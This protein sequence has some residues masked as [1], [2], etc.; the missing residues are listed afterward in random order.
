MRWNESGP[1][2]E[3]AAH[4]IEH[5]IARGEHALVEV[6]ELEEH[7]DL[8]YARCRADMAELSLLTKKDQKK[9]LVR[10]RDIA[11][12]AVREELRYRTT[13]LSTLHHEVNELVAFADENIG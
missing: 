1:H 8:A 4:F 12:R 11:S 5:R 3:A 6:V 10:V 13:L 9:A 7:S 2:N